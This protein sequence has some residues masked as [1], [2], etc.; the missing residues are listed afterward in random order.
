MRQILLNAVRSHAQ[1]HIDKHVANIEVYLNNPAGIGEHSDI[2]DA[3][4][5]ELKQIAEYQD[6]IDILDKY[7]PNV[8]N[9]ING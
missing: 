1:G 9:Q 2:V 7:F 3:I 5:M 4:E 8:T 6:Q